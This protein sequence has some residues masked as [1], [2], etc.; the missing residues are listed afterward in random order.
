MASEAASYREDVEQAR[1]RFVEFRETA[2]G[3]FAAAGAVVGCCGEVGAARWDCSYGGCWAWT[4]R[5]FKSGRIDWSLALPQSR[6]SLRAASAERECRT[7]LRGTAGHRPGNGRQLCGGS[8]IGQRRKAAAGSKKPSLPANW[9]S[10]I[11][12]FAAS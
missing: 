5:V 4:G 8:R 10:L 11:R 1:R 2:C 12:A 9:P 3:A 6:R 7:G